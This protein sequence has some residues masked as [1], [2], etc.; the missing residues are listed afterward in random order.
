[1]SEHHRCALSAAAAL[2]A[3]A[4]AMP[5]S[6]NATTISTVEQAVNIFTSGVVTSGAPLTVD[7]GGPKTVKGGVEFPGFAFGTYD[8]D[9]RPD[10]LSM[11]FVNDP[12]NLGIA[13][14][15]ASTVDRYY[16]AFD[17]EVVKA[18]ILSETPGFAATV[19][20][21]A[22]GDTASSVGAF[23]PGLPTSFVFDQGGILV[24]IGDG[25]DLNRVG[26]GGALDISVTAVPL[27]GSLPILLTGLASFAFVRRR[28]FASA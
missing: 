2:M 20:I 5:G 28:R 12:A 14:Y 13:V 25:T 18:S 16:Y 8:V 4:L 6:A 22:P 21:I 23:I 1:M 9:I 11:T 24:S 10:G 3:A 27:A 26:T 15:D 19:D 17:R 7:V